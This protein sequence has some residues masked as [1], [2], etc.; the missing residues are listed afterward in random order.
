MSTLTYS[1]ADHSQLPAGI[2]TLVVHGA[3]FSLLYFGVNWSNDP[4][5]GIEVEIWSE[6]PAPMV[7]Q[8]AIEPPPPPL[9][10]V[11]PVKPI[12]PPKLAEPIEPPKLDI[13]L[14]V[15][16]KPP[17]KLPKPVKPAEAKPVQPKQAEHVQVNSHALSL[18]AEQAAQIAQAAQARA[19]QG[20][21]TNK[22]VDEYVARI[23]AKI[24][25]N[26]VI[27]PDVPENIQA[28]FK[29]VLIPG[30]SVLSTRLV[31]PSGNSAYDEAVDRAI[32]K[33]DPLPLPPDVSLFSR[34]RELHLT[35]T[36]KE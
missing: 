5:K 29:V 8:A 23:R 19:A 25:R 18:Q 22:I 9:P 15:K 11:E 17:L 3:F 30:G 26:I 12:E 21:V 36:T 10:P 31:K 1:Y 27:P 24:K 33:A 14:P 7:K 13:V 20:A 34:F 4:P 6:L 16:K 2:L 32:M 35:F 28:E